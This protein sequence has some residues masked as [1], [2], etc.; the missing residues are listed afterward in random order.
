MRRGYDRKA[1]EILLDTI[2]K[3]VP[4]AQIISSFISG[5]P[6]ETHAEHKELIQFIEERRFRYINSFTYSPELGTAGYEMAGAVDETTARTWTLE[7]RDVQS[8]IFEANAKH[9]IGETLDVL[10]VG[11]TQKFPYQVNYPYEGRTQWDAPEDS[12]ILISSETAL[13]TGRFYPVKVTGF[14][15][16]TLLGEHITPQDEM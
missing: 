15:G 10:A 9:M 13:I 6:G 8:R 16:Y 3:R 12:R 7:L 1:V 2:A 11:Y 5:Y 14:D 4:N